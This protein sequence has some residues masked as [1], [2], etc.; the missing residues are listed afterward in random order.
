MASLNPIT[1]GAEEKLLM[2]PKF[3]SSRKG[4]TKQVIEITCK[5]L[6][7]VAGIEPVTPCLQGQEQKFN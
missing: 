7:D 4:P 2:G 5:W 1:K 3:Q 6:V